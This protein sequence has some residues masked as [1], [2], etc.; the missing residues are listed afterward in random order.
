MMTTAYRRNQMR[1]WR[2]KNKD[3]CRAYQLKWRAD[4]TYIEKMRVSRSESHRRHYMRIATYRRRWQNKKL[5]EDKVFKLERYTR[6]R[7]HKWIFT[8]S[9]RRIRA[10][11]RIAPI[12]GAEKSVVRGYIESQFK[13]GMTWQNHG[14]RGWQLDHVKPCREFDLSDPDQFAQCFHYTNLQPIWRAAHLEKH[15][16]KSRL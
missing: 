16:R 7:I 2:Q 1:K 9:S 13:D 8:F 15:G 10:K 14:Q 3:K 5:R 12:V 4:P 6:N 11:S